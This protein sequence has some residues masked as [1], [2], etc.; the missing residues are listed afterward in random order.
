[1][2]APDQPPVYTGAVSGKVFITNSQHTILC[3]PQQARVMAVELI[4]M[5]SL[6]EALMQNENDE[7]PRFSNAEL[8]RMVGRLVKA[9]YVW[10]GGGWTEAGESFKGQRQPYAKAT[11]DFYREAF[12]DSGK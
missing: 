7:T 6:A 12:K 9:G 11:V 10:K 4:R 1:M 8:D 3:E 2:S 5:A